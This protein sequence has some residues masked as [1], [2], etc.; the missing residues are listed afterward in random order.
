MELGDYASLVEVVKKAWTAVR[1]TKT[2][3]RYLSPTEAAFKEM[4]TLQKTRRRLFAD[5]AGRLPQYSA[6][7]K[8][9]RYASLLAE[10]TWIPSTP[11]QLAPPQQDLSDDSAQFVTTFGD[12]PSEGYLIGDHQSEEVLDRIRLLLPSEQAVRSPSLSR[13]I[14]SIERPNPERF[15]SRPSYSL[16]GVSR[17]TEGRLRLSFRKAYYFDYIDCGELLALEVIREF[18][19]LAQSDRALLLNEDPT[20]VAI[21][22]LLLRLQGRLKLRTLLGDWRMVRRRPSLAGVN[23]LTVF[24]DKASGEATFPMMQRSALAGTAGGTVHV[25]PAGEFQPTSSALADWSKHCTLWQTILRETAEEVLLHPEAESHSKQMEELAL[26][27][28]IS[29]M[30]SLIRTG[31]W[32][33]YFLGIGLDALT[34]KPEILV[35]SV[36]DRQAFQSAFATYLPNGS[37][38]GKDSEGDID[39]TGTGWGTRLTAENLRLYR[40]NPLALPAASGCI[41]LFARSASGI[42]GRHLQ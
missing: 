35:A 33:T 17:D 12:E 37:L 23:M 19:D 40:D 36:I 41:E 32:R 5:V 1:E 27:E 29:S 6:D 14:Q 38:P 4:R 13:T 34:L 8:P 10:Q 20:S 31:Q 24:L 21:D 25:I 28:P 15:Q 42:L 2:V 9:L 11:I 26:A 16:S 39:R 18:R 7:T 22:D 30:L 3:S